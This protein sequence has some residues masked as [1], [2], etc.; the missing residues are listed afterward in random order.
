MRVAQKYH[1]DKNPDNQDSIERFLAA[2]NAYENIMK[3]MQE[4]NFELFEK[5]RADEFYID[6]FSKTYNYIFIR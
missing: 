4:N 5:K 2:K 1:P 6:T 3:F